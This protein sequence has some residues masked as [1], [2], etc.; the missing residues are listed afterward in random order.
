MND[1]RIRFATI[2]DAAI[3]SHHDKYI[4]AALLKDKIIHK[5]V[6]VIYV[7]ES[8]AGWLRYNLFWD[9]IP[10]MNMLFLLPEYRGKGI[11]KKLV[12]FWE[13]EMKAQGHKRLMT[14]SQQNEFAQHFYVTLG[15]KA[16]GGFTLSGDSFEIIFE[17]EWFLK[18]QRKS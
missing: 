17:K 9:Q 5:E 4:T 15:Y 13:G 10:F 11:G 8:F 14:S 16:I 12:Q 6:I 7:R 18:Q 2:D 3:V 1:I